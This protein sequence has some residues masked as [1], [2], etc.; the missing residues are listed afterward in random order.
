MIAES[1]KSLPHKHECLSSILHTHVKKAGH[2]GTNLESIAEEKADRQNPEPRWPASPAYVAS[3]R[4]SERDF[5]S[6]V[7][8]EGSRE[9]KPEVDL[10]PLHT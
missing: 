9:K 1:V 6:K 3:S 8:E 5:V 7:Q 4:L 10:W 2:A